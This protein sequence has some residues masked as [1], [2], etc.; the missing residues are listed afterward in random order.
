MSLEGVTPLT[1][2]P[3]AGTAT[4]TQTVVATPAGVEAALAAAPLFD[5]TLPAFLGLGFPRPLAAEGS[6]LAVGDRRTIWFTGRNG[7]RAALVLEVVESEPGH[8]RFQARTDQ[9][10]IARWLGWQ[11]ADVT[12]QSTGADRTRVTW[13]LH[14]LRRLSPAW[15]FGPFEQYAATLSAKYL[16]ETAATPQ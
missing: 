7:S 9:T 5:R 11:D 15:Y 12:W 14:Y 13:T 1:S 8:V 10:P 3:S 16:I 2:F 6:G 4:A